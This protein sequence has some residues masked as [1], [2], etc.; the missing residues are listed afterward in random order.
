MSNIKITKNRYNRVLDVW[1]QFAPEESFAGM[2][3]AEF[4]AGVQSSIDERDRAAQAVLER[5]AAIASREVADIATR[6]LCKRVVSSIIGDSSHGADSALYRAMGYRTDADR[7]L[8]GLLIRRHSSMP[9]KGGLR[10]VWFP[11][12]RGHIFFWTNEIVLMWVKMVLTTVQRK[13][14]TFFI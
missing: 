13:S 10:Q 6:G 8:K 9:P 12:Q 3:L 2:T 11:L 5:R 1:A 14:L 4:K 7:S